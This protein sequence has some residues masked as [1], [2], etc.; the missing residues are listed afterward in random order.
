[1]ATQPGALRRGLNGAA[2][3]VVFPVLHGPMGEDG[4]IQGMFELSGIPYVGSGVLGSAISMDKAMTKTILAQAGLPQ[5]PWKLVARRDWER[6]PERITDEIEADLGFPCFVKPANMGSS[7]GV[8]KVHDAS[9]LP[10]AMTAAG[11][12]DRRILVEKGLDVRELEV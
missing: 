9:E 6:D 3:A 4:T 12:F 10:E 11:M 2:V 8:H 7:V 1:V 5:G